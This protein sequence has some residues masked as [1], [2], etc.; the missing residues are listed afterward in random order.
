MKIKRDQA[1]A[2]SALA[3]SAFRE[4]LVRFVQENCNGAARV[5][6][7]E[8]SQTVKF[9]I[10]R[11]ESYGIETER[12]V[13]IFVVTRWVIGEKFDSVFSQIER[14]LIDDSIGADEKTSRLREYAMDL[15]HTDRGEHP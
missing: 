2:L 13:A 6:R 14:M 15:L 10:E 7:S 1:G 11:A 4:R 5:S 9:L 3:R 8:L 12:Q